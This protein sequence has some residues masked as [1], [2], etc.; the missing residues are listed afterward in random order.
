MYPRIV[1][2]FV[3]VG[4]VGVV[5]FVEVVS[6]SRGEHVAGMLCDSNFRL[7]ESVCGWWC[8][9]VRDTSRALRQ[10]RRLRCNRKSRRFLIRRD[11]GEGECCVVGGDGFLVELPLHGVVGG[12]LVRAG[13]WLG[14]SMCTNLNSA[15]VDFDRGYRG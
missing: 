13:G 6:C 5:V 14:L 1:G 7:C 4:A 9:R 8:P 10:N 15:W 2:D 11:S 3:A 12:D